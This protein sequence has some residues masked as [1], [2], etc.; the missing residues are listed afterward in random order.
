[1]N[2]FIREQIE[3]AQER[4]ERDGLIIKGP[5]G[6]P[7]MN[8]YLDALAKLIDIQRAKDGRS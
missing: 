5:D 6:H 1:M 8:P 4:I 3:N 7:M 2:N